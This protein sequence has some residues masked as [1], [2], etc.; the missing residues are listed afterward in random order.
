ML[1]F[2]Q[3]ASLTPLTTFGIEARCQALCRVDSESYFLKVLE[4]S[5]KNSLPLHILGGGSNVLITH[6]LPGIVMVN[7]LKGVTVV[8]ENQEYLLVEFASGEIWH[9]CVK[10]AVSNALGGIENLALIPG[11][12]GAA[13]IQN[14]GAYGVELKDV[15][16]ELRAIELSSGKEFVFNASQCQFGYRDSIF[17]HAAKN[18][19]FITS[20][21]LRLFKNPSYKIDY[22][23]IKKILAEDY[24]GEI[25]IATIAASVEKIRKSK[26][27]DPMVIGNAG[28]FFK[29]PIIS[30]S[31]YDALKDSYPDMPSYMADNGVKIPAAWLIERTAPQGGSSWKGYR[32]GA[33]GVHDRQA[34]VL[35]NFGKAKGLEVVYLS[36]QIMISVFQKFNIQLEREVNIW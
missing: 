36:E 20:V 34:L 21:T 14:I 8:T 29:N 3:N 17:K 25:N 9:D 16:H 2:D 31:H 5:H 18:K 35:V 11:T 26:L 22:G 32:I 13:P 28:S 1:Q 24:F 7:T 33:V 19:Y 27:P 15:F 12:I 23:D 4:H 6:D 10:W 30:P